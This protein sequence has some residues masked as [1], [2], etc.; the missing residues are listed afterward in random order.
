MNDVANQ[1]IV[2]NH[3]VE[4]TTFVIHQTASEIGMA[5][6]QVGIIRDESPGHSHGL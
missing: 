3:V 4:L 5:F 2:L 1:I 6:L